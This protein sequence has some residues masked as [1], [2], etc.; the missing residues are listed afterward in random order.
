MSTISVVTLDEEKKK[1]K[2][3]LYVVQCKYFV[4]KSCLR[5]E[6]PLYVLF[7]KRDEFSNC[8]FKDG[9]QRARSKL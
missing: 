8:K 9:S 6:P 3:N 5:I 7:D 2:E 1:K 4:R